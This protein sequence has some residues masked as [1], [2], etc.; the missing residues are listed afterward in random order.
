MTGLGGPSVW[1]VVSPVFPYEEG[2]AVIGPDVFKTLWIVSGDVKGDIRIRGERLDGSGQAS[3]PTYEQEPGFYEER[4]AGT[5]E[6]RWERTELVLEA[7]YNRDHRTEVHYPSAGC[8]R[9]TVEVGFEVSQIV[10]YLY[11]P[12]SGE[13][14]RWLLRLPAE[15]GSPSS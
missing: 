9:F 13:N 14:A 5:W 2:G 3:F 11:P 10:L 7:P 12:D 8:W 1:M 15:P 4:R 6:P